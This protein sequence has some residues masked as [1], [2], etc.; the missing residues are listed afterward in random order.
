MSRSRNR[1]IGVGAAVAMAG[2]AMLTA[3]PTASADSAYGC[4]WPYVCFYK[5]KSDWDARK[6]TASFK[7]IT[8]YYQKLGSRSHGAY[9]IY[10]SRN[11]DGASIRYTNGS[12]LC[13]KPN[14]WR[15]NNSWTANGIK[16][17]NSASC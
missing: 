1:L 3:A 12:T 11:D 14:N 17:M 7:D 13:L 9:A 16:I 5:T 4:S 2:G 6:P 10:N 8:S 15:L